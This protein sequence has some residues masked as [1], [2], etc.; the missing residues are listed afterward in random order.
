MPELK[1]APTDDNLK[2][3]VRHLLT[4][5]KWDSLPM[6]FLY[7]WKDGELACS[8]C[9]VFADLEPD[10][11]P[12]GILKLMAKLM[13]E[14]ERPYLVVVQFEGHGVRVPQGPQAEKEEFD[15]QCREHELHTRDDA[16]ESLVIHGA[17]VDKRQCVGLRLRNGE[18][19]LVEMVSPGSH[20]SAISDAAIA[21]AKG[22]ALLQSGGE[23]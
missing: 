8:H 14:G 3:A 9:C 1:T 18:D 4:L 16:V 5:H 20:R 7:D 19:D 12:E 21:C 23:L 6:L 2:D 13:A 22:V 11:L 10:E 17:A 15:R